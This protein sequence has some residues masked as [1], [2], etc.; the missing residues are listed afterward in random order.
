MPVRNRLVF[1]SALSAVATVAAGVTVLLLAT[2]TFGWAGP[3]AT[4]GAAAVAA[5]AAGLVVVG[6][7]RTA[8]D[9][10]ETLAE[11]A[12]RLGQGPVR[13]RL[14]AAADPAVRAI[15]GA[16]NHASVDLRIR[17]RDLDRTRSDFRQALTRL[18][19]VLASTHDFE[20]IVDAIVETAL[21]VAPADAAV[22][23]RLA[24][25][26]DHLEV[27]RSRG[28][29]PAGMLL[30]GSGLAG[31]AARGRSVVS[32]STPVAP[33]G[34]VLTPADLDPSEPAAVAGLAGPLHSLGRLVGVVAVYG[35][36]LGRPFTEEE[37]GL[38]LSLMRQ[39]EV[40]IANIELH[41]R[42]RRDALTD[43]LTGLSNRR[44][45]DMRLHDAVA[46][47]ER[48]GEPFSVAMF[49]VDDFKR[50]N[51]TWD[52]GTGDAALIHLA[53]ILRQV[54][55]EVDVVCR[56]G[57]EEFVV[58]LQRADPAVAA[59][60][61][62]RVVDQVRANPFERAGQRIAFTV[63]GG[64]AGFPQDGRD[65]VEVVARADSA[66]LRAKAGGKDR[67]ERASTTAGARFVVDVTEREP[68]AVSENTGTPPPP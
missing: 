8:V 44:Y 1:V 34:R 43:G 51:D 26:P 15:A 18:G 49:D 28:V 20:G 35:T 19:E 37:T 32:L 7:L 24:V 33:P 42:A 16:L 48:Y 55:R 27:L 41:E 9:P 45:F 3:L 39:V 11:A 31:A 30:A 38:L 21:L 46:A 10:L 25:S 58:L 6:A 12:G 14:N 61:A 64:V 54:T 62:P 67:V 17:Q 36:G 63:S 52:H 29:P 60:A 4:A 65:G 2:G 47:A 66:L 57:G 56:W 22:C 5:V 50:I 59:S 53:Q 23:Y 68:L 13:V 40:A